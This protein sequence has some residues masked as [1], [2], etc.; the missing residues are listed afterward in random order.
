MIKN[1][2]VDFGQVIVHFDPF[3]MTSQYIEDNND[4]D[5]VQEVVFDRLYW[6][7]LDDGTITDEEVKQGIRSRLPE[8]LQKSACDAYDNWHRN[9]PFV[10]GMPELLKQIKRNGGRLFL[11]SNISIGFAENYSSVAEIKEIFDLFD[12]LVFSGPLGLTKP[13]KEIF[14]YL[15]KKYNLKAE[16]SIFIDDNASNISGAQSVGIK[17]YLFDNCNNLKNYYARIE[18]RG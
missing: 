16:E 1:Y 7:K 2:I 17:G 5:L 12:G 15:I 3:Y 18:K 14:E 6:D 8:C 9:L 13:A 11:L 4:I 10:E